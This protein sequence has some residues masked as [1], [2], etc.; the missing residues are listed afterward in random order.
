MIFICCTYFGIQ[1]SGN[2]YD[3]NNEQV[4]VF[5]MEDDEDE[6]TLEDVTNF[7]DYLDSKPPEKSTKAKP[8]N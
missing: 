4:H 8:S 3:E 6:Y 1:K 5:E 2:I 7:N